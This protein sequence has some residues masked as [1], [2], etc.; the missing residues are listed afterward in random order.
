MFC[1]FGFQLVCG[2]ESEVPVF[3]DA[4]TGKEDKWSTIS[5]SDMFNNDGH[6]A[7]IRSFL[8]RP[9]EAPGPLAL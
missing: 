5:N 2:A 8:W 4:G 9:T 1:C 7:G 6:S 3:H